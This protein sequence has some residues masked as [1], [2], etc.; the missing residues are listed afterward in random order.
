MLTFGGKVRY[1]MFYSL[2]FSP[3]GGTKKV[4][5]ILSKALSDEVNEIDITAPGSM[6]SISFSS[7]DVVLVSVPSYGGRVPK[8]ALERLGRIN[9]KSTRAIALVVY[10]ER[11][12]ED[13]L[14]EL[15]D[16]LKASGFIIS[17][18]IAA[19]AEHSIVREVASGRPDERDV[20]DLMA[21]AGKVKRKLD[22]GSR[23]EAS[24]PGNHP[25]RERAKTFP[26]PIVDGKCKKCMLCA[27]LCPAGAI[28]KDDPAILDEGKCISC[29]RCVSICPGKAR[30]IDKGIYQKTKTMLENMISSRKAPEVHL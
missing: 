15:G 29:M 6:H 2:Y 3:T 4:A 10:G 28:D 24:I 5:G 13:T 17:A 30:N 1:R 26:K 7:E 27:S 16:T 8:S 9:G 22:S 18:G 11:A 19:I 20:Y 21:I 12:Y 23:E 25:Y 14:L